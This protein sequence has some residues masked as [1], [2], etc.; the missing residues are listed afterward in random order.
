MRPEHHGHFI[1]SHLLLVNG[2][3]SRHTVPI[4][5]LACALTMVGLVVGIVPTTGIGRS[6][7]VHA[8]AAPVSTPPPLT[9]DQMRHV[10]AVLAFYDAYNRH[11]VGTLLSLLASPFRYDDCNFSTHR[12]VEIEAAQ[13]LR[14]WLRARFSDHDQFQVVGDFGADPGPGMAGVQGDV[15]RHSDSLDPLVSRG[16]IPSDNNGLGKF[17]VTA[18]DKI[19]LAGIAGTNFCLAG[20]RPHGAK[21][22]QERALANAFV[23]TYNR[24]D[25]RGVLNTLA[26]TVSYSDCSTAG[27]TAKA[28]TLSG[29]SA[30]AAWLRSRFMAGDHIGHAK[31]LLDSY[32]SEPP[33]SS[34]IVVIR[35][36]RAPA[37]G[38]DPPSQPI[39][40][41]ITPS[42]ALKQIQMWQVW[43]GC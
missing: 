21:P 15:I 40:V 34:Q 20:T 8:Q 14:R 26:P 33:N 38:S 22:R 7:A 32:L 29:R 11:D 9:P 31:V 35:G 1:C 37:T 19:E 12:P 10:Q 27:G 5:V 17:V 30:V 6:G 36:V 3:R 28:Q 24:H 4:R 43:S 16:L 13:P 39:T 41:R 2:K 25:L 42:F 18:S 23:R